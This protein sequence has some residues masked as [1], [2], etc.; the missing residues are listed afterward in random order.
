MLGWKCSSPGA[1]SRLSSSKQSSMQM[2]VNLTC[3]VMP[4][5][6][7]SYQDQSKIKKL[8]RIILLSFL[9]LKYF[10]SCWCS[11]I[12]VIIFFIIYSILNV[13][14]T[15]SHCIDFIHWYV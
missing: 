3:D 8:G 9:R 12:A 7:Y 10:S 11:Y 4:I 2:E 6:R 13:G 14:K 1:H 5:S 15:V